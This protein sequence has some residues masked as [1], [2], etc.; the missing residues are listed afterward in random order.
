M[1][2]RKKLKKLE[3]LYA[4]IPNI[5][6]KGLCYLSCSIIPASKVEMKRVKAK[7]QINPFYS[8][9]E[10]IVKVSRIEKVKGK[11]PACAALVNGLCTIY[12]D[13][14]AICRLYGVVENMQCEFG[15]IPEKM[16]TAQQGYDL[17]EKIENL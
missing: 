8:M 13:R 16:L 1:L 14:P 17:I 3:Q 6:C 12:S 10:A 7:H 5:E 15:C 4:Q 11:F 2:D 9:P